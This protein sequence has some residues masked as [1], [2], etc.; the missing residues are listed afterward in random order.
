VKSFIDR[1][2]GAFAAASALLVLVLFLYEAVD[3]FSSATD[4]VVHTSDVKVAIG[5]L[6][7]A[8][9]EA[10]AAA[11]GYRLT[12]DPRELKRF[13]AAAGQVDPRILAVRKLTTDNARQQAALGELE[14]LSQA[15]LGELRSVIGRPD[16]SAPDP[17][18]APAGLD[19]GDVR[20]DGLRRVLSAM[21]SEEDQLAGKRKHAAGTQGAKVL[22]TIVISS[23]VLGGLAVFGWYRERIVDER[24][25]YLQAQAESV[26]REN[27]VLA[28]RARASEFQERFIA[29]LGHDLRNPLGSLT[30]GIDFL[31]RSATSDVQ[32]RTLERMS[33]SAARIGR[34]IEQLLDLAR[35][36]LGDG[37]P[38]HRSTA[39]LSSIV[40][41]VAE[42]CRAAHPS[43]TIE[44]EQH[45]DARGQW[46]G[47]RLAQVVSNLVGNAVSYGTQQAP[48]RIELIGEDQSVTVA[49][50]NDGAPIPPDLQKVIFDPFRRGSR[51]SRD[52]RTAG[53]GLGLYI[54][55]KI[56]QAH[57]GTL[58]LSSTAEA[59]TS[60]SFSL[61][62]R[63]SDDLPRG[64][65]AET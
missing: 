1:R 51:D 29:I 24:K 22:V 32:A 36:R 17:I 20:M 18:V 7:L 21:Q 6:S 16:A 27:V 12:G 2:L 45:G 23:V 64:T 9:S 60:F 30:M 47:E 35:T 42:E 10:S 53:L 31:R 41:D 19:D 44:I 62:R 59:G 38:V 58:G 5:E 57:G 54:T 26:A 15:R 34:M 65:A 3:G 4:R 43:C 37:I 33:R 14:R 39:D 48:V 8:L 40:A 55:K 52:A 13:D 28:E 56:V 61:P 50:K 46:D 49:V 11:S 63:V 25:R